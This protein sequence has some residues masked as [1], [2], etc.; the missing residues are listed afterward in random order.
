MTLA[1]GRPGLFVL[2][3]AEG[4]AVVH[5]AFLVK[6]NLLLL[7]QTNTFLFHLVSLKSDTAF[8]LLYQHVILSNIILHTVI[9]PTVILSMNESSQIF[10]ST[11]VSM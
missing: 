2:T 6:D 11:Q 9:L 10:N 3:P 8:C 4:Q 1:P 5:P 7:N